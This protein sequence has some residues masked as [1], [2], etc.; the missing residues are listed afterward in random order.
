MLGGEQESHA[1]K[2]FRSEFDGTGGP[3]RPVAP[4]DHPVSGTL[5]L[6]SMPGSIEQ[7][8]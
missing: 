6:L 1:A 8:S 4:K 5:D 3:K 2:F 7:T